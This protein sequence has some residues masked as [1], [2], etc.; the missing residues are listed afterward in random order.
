MTYG[1]STFLCD[2]VKAKCISHQVK[3]LRTLCAAVEILK[4]G[5]NLQRKL[6]AVISSYLKATVFLSLMIS[7]FYT[8][9]MKVITVFNAE[10][11]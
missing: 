1:I 9:K 4:A 6:M 2:G 11:A 7:V 5:R 8:L 10:K 3:S